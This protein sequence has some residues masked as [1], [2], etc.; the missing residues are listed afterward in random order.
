MFR[1]TFTRLVIFAVLVAMC[2]S[3][4]QKLNSKIALQNEKIHRS[5]AFLPQN[6]YLNSRAPLYLI[7]F[8]TTDDTTA[9]SSTSTQLLSVLIIMTSYHH[10]QF[11]NFAG[12]RF[13]GC[14]KHN[15]KWFG[16][17]YRPI[18]IRYVDRPSHFINRG[19]SSRSSELRSKCKLSNELN[20]TNIHLRAL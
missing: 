15:R 3:V 17:V 4:R 20:L 5:H 8:Q 13:T 19:S 12:T 6:R 7:F 1:F 2:Y 9:S 18:A 14:S 10:D 16:L 11:A